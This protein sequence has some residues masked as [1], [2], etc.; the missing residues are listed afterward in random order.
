M[1]GLE[2]GDCG[3]GKIGEGGCEGVAAVLRVKELKKTDARIVWA[4]TRG[5][6]PL[7]VHISTLNYNESM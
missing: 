3:D 5:R 2:M 6:N 7:V 4:R 1:E